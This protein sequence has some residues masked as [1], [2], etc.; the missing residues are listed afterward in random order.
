MNIIRIINLIENFAP[1][2]LQESWDCS[3]LQV[4]L[5]GKNIKRILLCL[6]ITQNIIEQAIEK[7]CNMIISHHPLFFVPFEFNKNISI[8]SAHT[9]LDKAD[10]GTTDTLIKLLGFNKSQK[11]GEFLRLVELENEFS[12]DDFVKLIKE[13]LNLK[14][15]RVVNN[16]NREKVRKLAFC[17]GSGSDF[18]REAEKIFADILITGD[19]K[20]HVAFDSNIIIADIG[21]FE[22]EYPVLKTLEELLKNKGIE[23]ITANEKSPFIDC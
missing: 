15:V 3:G 19:V 10:G 5:G 1:I 9:N 11:I 4:D 16:F 7:N 14:I 8:Y 12:L 21:H 2:E 18:L 17:A 6:S 13:K 22:S 20:Y 23:V